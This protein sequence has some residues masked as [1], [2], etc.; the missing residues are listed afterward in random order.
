[1]SNYETITAI[2]D[3]LE[4][5]LKGLGVNFTRTVYEDMASIPTSL[6]PLGEI[7][8][9]RESFEHPSGMKSGYC[10]AGFRLK[11]TLKENNPRDMQLAQMYWIHKIRD[12]ITVNALNIGSLASS[13]LVSTIITESARP[14]N[15]HYEAVAAIIYE[16]KI[17]YREV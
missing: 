2:T 11:V 7:I 12:R 8:Y 16:I 15:V 9:N 6:L 17:R 13:K 1:M 14:E 3:N 10:E 4:A 5:V